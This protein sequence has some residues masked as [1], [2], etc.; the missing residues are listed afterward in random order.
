M[1]IALRRACPPG[2][3]QAPETDGQPLTSSC[4][5]PTS[6]PRLRRGTKYALVNTLQT[7][8]PAAAVVSRIAWVPCLGADA[9]V[10]RRL[11]APLAITKTVD[12]AAP[13]DAATLKD[14]T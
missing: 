5:A 9:A 3:A 6:A 10:G 1:H 11:Q 2:A 8:E 4:A 12:T 13:E 7:P 14:V